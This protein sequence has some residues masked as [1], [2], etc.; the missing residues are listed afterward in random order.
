M[1]MLSTP[2]IWTTTW[3]GMYGAKTAKCIKLWSSDKFIVRLKRT[4]L[5]VSSSFLAV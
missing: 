2:I 3:L 4:V 5:A 1:F